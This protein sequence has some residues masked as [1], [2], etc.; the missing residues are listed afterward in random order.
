MNPG[1][2]HLNESWSVRLEPIT[3]A[4]QPI[5]NI[6]TGVCYGY[7]ALLRN[8]RGAG[9]DSIAAVF[10]EAYSNG[11]L[12]KVDLF[13]RRKA[14]RKYAKIPWSKSVKLFYNLDNRLFSSTD[15]SSGDTGAILDR[16]SLGNDNIVFEIS[17]RH[18][19]ADK[20]QTVST[21][22][23]Y[24]RQG[25]KIAVDD[26][27]T[28]FSGLQLLYY[29][30]PDCIKIDRFFIQDIESDSKKRLFVSSIVEIAHQMGSIVVAEGVE[31]RKEYYSCRSIGCDLIQGYFLQ[32]PQLEIKNLKQTYHEIE[33]LSQSEMRNRATLDKTLIKTEMEYIEPVPLDSGIIEIFETFRT[34]KDKSFF[35]VIN[36]NAQL[37]GIIRESSFKEFAYS[38]F[39]RQLLENPNFGGNIHTFISRF[40][41]A[42]IHLPVEKILKIFAQNDSSEGIMIL[43]GLT[44]MGFLSAM[45]LLKIVN[46]KNLSIAREQNP[47]TKLP[48]NALIYEH[49]STA[50][51]D[52]SRTYHFIY[53]D[54]DNFKS[55]ND[56]YGFRHGDRLILRFA[57]LLKSENTA[58]DRFVGHIGGDDFFLCIQG[59]ELEGIIEAT[60]RIARRFKMDAES[61]YDIEDR[62][63][64][65]IVTYGRDGREYKAPLITVSSVIL[66]LP[67]SIRR[68]NNT[69]DIGNII[70]DL[71]K[72]AKNSEDKL[73]ISDISDLPSLPFR[74]AS[75]ME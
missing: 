68:V 13:L 46:E 57:E 44:Y 31:T 18:E 35:P 21:L 59:G 33:L 63:R 69:E 51:Q 29:T 24:R 43:D 4:F 34:Q 32:E 17:E 42:D 70:A 71:K 15:Y 10:D 40:P 16:L 50:I 14:F 12:H 73:C 25:Y 19:L 53:F 75:G 60:K 38:R 6:H 26:C 1:L 11:I 41:V 72:T 3:F 9:F 66:Q 74:R 67:G 37:V 23:A 65:H 48:G 47:L 58:E 36:K 54:F 64:G 28:G 20:N 45:S 49:I 27:G 62:N 5:V 7:E 39:G 2:Q 22:Q 52:E 56:K 30:E 8:F 55:Y 61:F